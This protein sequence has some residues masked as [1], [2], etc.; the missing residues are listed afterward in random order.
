[1][2]PRENWFIKNIFSIIALVLTISGIVGGYA[3]LQ[4]RVN[5]IQTSPHID[6]ETIRAVAS[7][8]VTDK[9]AIINKDIL[10]LQDRINRMEDSTKN[11]YRLMGESKRMPMINVPAAR[12]MK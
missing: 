11:I 3:Q 12:D 2:P 1:M 10:Y 5:L 7:E 8:V 4:Y 6:K 9:L